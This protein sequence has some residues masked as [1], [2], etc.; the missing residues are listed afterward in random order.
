MEGRGGGERAW[1]VRAQ[2][3]YDCASLAPENENDF[4]RVELVRALLQFGAEQAAMQIA[5]EIMGTSNL[6]QSEKQQEKGVASALAVAA[7]PVMSRMGQLQEAEQHLIHALNA[8]PPPCAE[9]DIAS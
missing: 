5:A 9:Q 1:L 3:G 2:R 6:F 8:P 7:A 4:F